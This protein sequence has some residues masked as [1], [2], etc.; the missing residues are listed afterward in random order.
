VRR[1][2]AGHPNHFGIRLEFR[3]Y[4]ATGHYSFTVGA[5]PRGGYVV[6]REE[7]SLIRWGTDSGR[8]HFRVKEGEIVEC[9][10]TPAPAPSSDRLYLVNA[11]GL[12]TFRPLYDALSAIGIYNINP[13]QVRE[14]Q[15]PDPGDLLKRDGSNLAS[16]V[17]RLE[18]HA[19]ERKKRIVEYLSKVVP[20]VTGVA[21]SAIG[22]K[23]T[24]E[25]LQQV[26]GAKDPWRFPASNMSDGT[27]RALGV[28]T[29]L[30]QAGSNGR[31]LRRLVGVEEPEVALH[32]AAAGV[33]T[34][35]LRDASHFAQVV[36]TSHSPDLLDDEEIAADSILAVV[37]D[38]GET[39]IGPLD[40]SGRSVL[41]DHLYTAG[42]LLRLDQLR[43]DPEQSRPTQLDLFDVES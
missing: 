8:D 30:F 43:P 19:P 40:E 35:G 34:D 38:Q 24:L 14:L 11:S 10:V 4:E 23:E 13:D 20:G 36:V 12:A 41:R 33:L 27:L 16:V 17:A 21:A 32:P 15:S 7:C 29:A 1:R 2:S 9:S 37:S 28:L 25:F 18:A 5:Q 22:P 42:E 39:R 6:K 31:G 3:L 26:G